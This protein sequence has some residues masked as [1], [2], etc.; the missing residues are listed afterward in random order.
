MP[1]PETVLVGAFS[2]RYLNS[3][4]MN[5]VGSVMVEIASSLVLNFIQSATE[6]L[7]KHQLFSR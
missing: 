7:Y 4:K 1:Q 2:I 5:F 6:I 3:S